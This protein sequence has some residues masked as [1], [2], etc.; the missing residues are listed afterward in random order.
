ML[1]LGPVAVDVRPNAITIGNPVFNGLWTYLGTP[2]VTLPLFQSDDG[3]PIG[4]QLV[5]RPGADAVVLAAGTAL[6]RRLA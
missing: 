2:A 6:L 1:R 4:V 3:L 5:G